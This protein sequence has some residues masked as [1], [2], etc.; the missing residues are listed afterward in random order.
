MLLEEKE[1]K[2]VF[3]LKHRHDDKDYRTNENNLLDKTLS[4][5][6]YNNDTMNFFLKNLQKLVH[7]FFDK[8]NIVRNFKNPTVDKYDFRHLD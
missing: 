4:P 5:Y 7:M 1:I 8:M 2:E 6:I 3:F